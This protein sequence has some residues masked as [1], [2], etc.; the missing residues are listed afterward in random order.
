MYV[1]GLGRRPGQRTSPPGDGGVSMSGRLDALATAAREWS[2]AVEHDPGERH[3]RYAGACPMT[4][5]QDFGGGPGTVTVSDDHRHA[6]CM[7]CHADAAVLADGFGLPAPAPLPPRA[8]SSQL[9]RMRLVDMAA[10][11]AKPWTPDRYR[12]D[13]LAQDGALTILCGRSGC[14]KSWVGMALLRGVHLGRPVAGMACERGRA[15][16]VDGEMGTRIAADRHRA[17]G[18]TGEEFAYLDCTGLNLGD[19]AGADALAERIREHRAT[20]V[21]IDSLRRLTPGCKENDSDQMAFVIGALAVVARETGCAIVLLHHQG[22]G[23]DAHAS[24]GSSAILDQADALLLLTAAEDGTLTLSASASKGC[25]YRFGEVPHDRYF[26]LDLDGGDI[27]AAAEPPAGTAPR[28][29]PVRAAVEAQL[30][31]L[32]TEDPGLTRADALRGIGRKPSDATGREVWAELVAQGV[33]VVAAPQGPEDNNNLGPAP[34]EPG[35][36]SWTPVGP[37][38][39]DEDGGDE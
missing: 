7:W 35:G 14:G 37:P 9:A 8:A 27:L 30:R 28:V 13:R 23:E 34:W 16:Y 10:E 39:S 26:R 29:P 20:L 24:R 22:Y 31:E 18:L 6:E 38:A 33:V 19:Q 17:A 36:G 21:V 32:L 12:V 2:T 15:L 5:C 3:T 1:H 4:G 25:K 11:I